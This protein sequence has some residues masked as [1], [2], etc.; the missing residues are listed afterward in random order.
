MAEPLGPRNQDPYSRQ[1]PPASVTNQR[2]RRYALRTFLLPIALFF[3]G[4]A[5][6]LAYWTLSSPESGQQ[7][8][9]PRAEATTGTERVG[10]RERT[11]GGFNPYTTPQQTKEEIAQRGGRT[12]TELGEVLEEGGRGVLGLRVDLRDIDVE[13]VESPT[14]FW[15][16]DGNARVAVNAVSGAQVKAGQT[17]NVVGTVERHGNSMRIRASRVESSQ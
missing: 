14:L 2:V 7:R 1:D 15:I 16:R 6:V 12:I 17:V 13:R 11:P 4:I 5:L 10:S 9:E 3:A 8:G